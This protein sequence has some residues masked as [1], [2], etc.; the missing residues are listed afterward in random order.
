MQITSPLPHHIFLGR[1][2]GEGRN[3]GRT[4]ERC[5]EILSER[6]ALQ[7]RFRSED[8]APAAHWPRTLR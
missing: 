2:S 6:T 8:K 3:D 4:G 7:R 5:D 1:H